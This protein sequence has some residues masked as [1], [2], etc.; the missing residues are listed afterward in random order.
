MVLNAVFR[1]CLGLILTVDCDFF[2]F[3]DYT[4]FLMFSN[5]SSR[6]RGIQSVKITLIKSHLN[7][8]DVTGGIV[9]MNNRKMVVFTGCGLVL[10]YHAQ[11]TTY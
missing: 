3:N 4:E 11:S 10:R 7:S 2:Q 9:H 6:G 1:I 5:A 8:I